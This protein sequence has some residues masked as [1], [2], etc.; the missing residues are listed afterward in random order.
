MALCSLHHVIDLEWMKEAYRLTRKDG[1]TGIDGVTATDYEVN[2]EARLL[3]LL[4]RIKS[5]RYRA[6]P[7]RRAYIPKADGAQRM[8][9]I[10]TFED[11]VAQRA[12]TMVLEAV[13]EEDFY[14]CSYGFRPGRSAHQALHAL[15]SEL[16][17]KRLYWVVDI[18]IRKYFDSIPHSHLRA[19][20]DQRVTDG[21]IRRM[22]D[23]WLGAGAVEDGVLRRTTEGSPQGG[24]VSPCLS[25]IFL[26]Y[27]LD[28]WFETEVR[29]RL[30]GTCTLA[31][32][33]DDAVMAFDNIVDAQR[34]LAVLGKRLERFGL[35][36]H[37]DK[38]RLVDFRPQRTE[39]TRHPETDGANFDFLGLTHVWGRSRRGKDMVMQFTAKGR[40]ARGLAAVS[41]WCR[42]TGI[43]RSVT[44]IATSPPCCGATSP[45]TAS[46]AIVGVCDGSPIR[47]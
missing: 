9:G 17:G 7:V 36:L 15:R 23:K 1:A 26:H 29:P 14:P 39:R 24:V 37:P 32:Y 21:I 4:G 8:L 34:V 25:N 40:F 19:F 11:K 35:T 18:D 33:A 13:Y 43:G 30:R 31:R 2:L 38:T 16:W 46:V 44:S 5:G 47:S 6:P 27:V 45:T 10:P 3:D 41:D 42:Q 28:D 22:I 20:L 12:V